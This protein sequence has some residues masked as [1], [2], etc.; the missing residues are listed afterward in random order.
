TQGVT[1][2]VAAAICPSIC[3][4]NKKPRLSRGFC[5]NDEKAL[6]LPQ[7]A[8]EGVC[9]RILAEFEVGQGGVLKRRIY[10]YRA[11]YIA[12]HTVCVVE[13][14]GSHGGAIISNSQVAV[15]AGSFME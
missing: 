3:N 13:A 5:S 11:G 7:G 8:P 10:S 14:G 2:Q 12:Y 9:S 4:S 1:G 6:S 15:F